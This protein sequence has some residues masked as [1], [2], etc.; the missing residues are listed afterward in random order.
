MYAQARQNAAEFLKVETKNL[1]LDHNATSCLNKLLKL[2][3]QPIFSDFDQVELF[4]SDYNYVGMAMSLKHYFPKQDSLE[5]EKFK[6][7]TLNVDDFYF[8]DPAGDPTQNKLHQISS[9]SLKIGQKTLKIC[10]LDHIVSA[11]AS[12]FRHSTLKN[13]VQHFQKLETQDATGG[14]QVITIIDGAHAFGL[15][16]NLKIAEFEADF[17]LGNFHKWCYSGKTV[18]ALWRKNPEKFGV[19]TEQ[20]FDLVKD[21]NNFPNLLPVSKGLEFYQNLVTFEGLKNHC[22]TIFEQVDHLFKN[23]AQKEKQNGTHC[24]LI[25]PDFDKFRHQHPISMRLYQLSDNFT[26]RLE[27][28]NGCQHDWIIDILMEKFGQITYITVKENKM[29]LRLSCN[30]Y[31]TID[32]YVKF[33]TMMTKLLKIKNLGGEKLNS[34][35]K[36]MSEFWN[37]NSYFGTTNTKRSILMIN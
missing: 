15:F 21:S 36:M 32:D 16:E 29:Y 24:S 3:L 26:N 12:Q 23:Q 17:Y 10:F 37:A 28:K 4:I 7:H 13:L 9:Q 35:T 11:S 1:I 6:I 8:F 25:H 18:A 34:E 30:V 14:T 19:P 22:C 33:L 20:Y 5:K 2:E 27:F 31:N